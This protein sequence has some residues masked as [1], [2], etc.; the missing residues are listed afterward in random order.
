MLTN[1]NI[2][3]GPTERLRWDSEPTNEKAGKESS[4]NKRI[5]MGV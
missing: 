1:I 5:F 4:Q 2:E 3:S